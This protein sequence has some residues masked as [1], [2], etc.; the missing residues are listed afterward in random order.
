[1]S[2]EI[3]GV[4]LGFVGVAIFSLTLPATR[5]AV[6]GGLDPMFVALGRAVLAAFIAGIILLITKQ[7]VPPKRFWKRLFFVSFGIV[8]GFPLCMTFAMKSLPASHGGIVLGVLPLATTAAAAVF[9]WE[10][11]GIGFWILA[12]LGSSL[13][14]IFAMIEGAGDLQTADLLLLAA[15]AFGGIG[16][17]M[18][19]DLSR[20][21]G[22]WQVICWALIVSLPF[23]IP[24]FLWILLDANWQVS[25]LTWGGFIYVS[26]FSQL[27][28]FFAWNRALALGGV[29]K[30][31]QIQLLQL[32]MTLLG[33]SLLLGEE[34]DE[35]TIFFA[36]CVVVVV[37]IGRRMPVKRKILST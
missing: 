11:P 34:I 15:A 4:I 12:I 20:L 31:G 27:I 14:V 13:V 3:K 37:A 24:P 19:G 22:G 28:G 21:L 17:A 23:I 30:I 36:T 26:L 32:F 1:M 16:Y 29:S 10:R 9:C 2:N 18:S 8:L 7:S 33:S 35:V 6:V 5:I 25:S